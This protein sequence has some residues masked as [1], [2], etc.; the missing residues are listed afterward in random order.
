MYSMSSSPQGIQI[1]TSIDGISWV[2]ENHFAISET[3][4]DTSGIKSGIPSAGLD[5]MGGTSYKDGFYYICARLS[6]NI[7]KINENNFNEEVV[8]NYDSLVYDGN[9]SNVIIPLNV[10]ISI[11]DKGSM[12]VI[13]YYNNNVGFKILTSKTGNKN[14]WDLKLYKPSLF[15][16]LNQN[17]TSFPAKYSKLIP[18]SGESF[19]LSDATNMYFSITPDL[20]ETEVYTYNL[21]VAVNVQTG[22]NNFSFV[23]NQV[24]DEI[25]IDIPA[26]T[27]GNTHKQVLLD[28]T[29]N[30]GF[31]TID[32]SDKN[33]A[34][35]TAYYVKAK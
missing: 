18:I 33:L 7:Y 34:D 29:L 30:S 12:A 17:Q 5:G 13:V 6:R 24:S 4:N 31:K 8:F 25:L 32:L 14:D 26:R 9:T 21:G 16:Q 3:D 27:T 2:L 19:M 23:Y 15:N 35:N 1:Y 20:F 10:G 28:I 22:I 11:T